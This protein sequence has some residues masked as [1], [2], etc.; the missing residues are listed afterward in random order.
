MSVVAV[1][2]IALVLF[3]TQKPPTSTADLQTPPAQAAGTAAADLADGEELGKA[4]ATV[5]LEIWSDFQCPI[6]GTLVKDYFPR[7]ITDFV[8]TGQVRIVAHDIAILGATADNESV[9]S[10]VG[11]VCAGDQGKYWKYHDYLFYN[12]NGENKGWFNADRLKTFAE[13]VGVDMGKWSA[14]IAD[15]ARTQLIKTN[16]AQALQAGISSTP[17]FRVAGGKVTSGLPRAYADFAAMIR[18]GLPSASP[19]AASAA[20]SAAASPLATK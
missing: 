20:P 13:F 6:C 8:R 4:D 9:S 12:Q 1:V 19:A 18:A 3:L 16:T 15:P 10:A 14:C 7:L 11:A 2:A 17:S 5:K